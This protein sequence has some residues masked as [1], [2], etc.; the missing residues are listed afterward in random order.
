MS[1]SHLH[2]HTIFIGQQNDVDNLD[3][4]INTLP[5][6]NNVGESSSLSQG[7]HDWETDHP[8]LTVLPLG[9]TPLIQN[10][11]SLLDDVA[12]QEPDASLCRKDI[13]K[14]SRLRHWSRGHQFIVRGG[15]H[16]DI[17]QPLY[18]CGTFDYC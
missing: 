13:G 17:R 3:E 12:L 11:P 8:F 15:G 7:M 5:I 1:F 14:R 6:S 9:I 16:I 10:N 4:V 2:V 18:R